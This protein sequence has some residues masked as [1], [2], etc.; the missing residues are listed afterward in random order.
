MDYFF[1]VREFSRFRNFH[2]KEVFMVKNFSRKSLLS[3]Y[4]MF[5]YPIVHAQ[6]IDRDFFSKILFYRESRWFYRKKKNTASEATG[7]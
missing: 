2:G 7:D 5:P 3:L 4:N 6:N 1:T